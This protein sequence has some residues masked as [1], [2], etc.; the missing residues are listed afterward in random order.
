M[1]RHGQTVYVIWAKWTIRGLL[2]A[3]ATLCLMTF[4][5]CHVLRCIYCM[6]FVRRNCYWT[7]MM[8]MM[9]MMMILCTEFTLI[10][11][12][13]SW[14]V[15]FCHVNT[16]CH[17]T[18]WPSHLSPWRWKFAVHMVARGHSPIFLTGNTSTCYVHWTGTISECPVIVV[19]RIADVYVVDVHAV[20]GWDVR[21]AAAGHQP[22]AASSVV[23]N[24]RPVSRTT[25]ALRH[26]GI[27]FKAIRLSRNY[28]FA[29]VCLYVLTIT[30]TVAKIAQ[31]QPGKSI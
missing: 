12:V 22:A 26:V 9:M 29:S 5:T 21:T 19:C 24:A 10:P 31:R 15:T 3:L 7:K 17:V 14:N 8:M 6:I 18:L 1:L 2:I 27:F 23:V 25:G 4:S 13:I 28:D 16:S 30:Q 11:H 20:G